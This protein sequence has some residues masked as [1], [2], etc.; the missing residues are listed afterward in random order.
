MIELIQFPFSSF[1]L[2][3]RR[4]LEY[5]GVL[6]KITNIPSTDRTLVWRL[7]RQRYYGVPIVRDGRTVVFETDEYSQVVAK[8]ID[9]KLQLNLFPTSFR[10]VDRIMWRYIED[11]VEDPCFKLNNVYWEKLV[12][13]G[14]RLA[15][16]RHKE[17][18]FGR[19]CLDQ[20]REQ[21]PQLLAQLTDALVPFEC[22]LAERPY[23][24]QTR[25]HFIDFELWGMLA[26]FLYTGDYKFPA[27]HTSLN[28]WYAR[29]SKL[30][31]ADLPSEKLH[32]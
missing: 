30:R 27:V 23:L 14:E 26:C 19:G 29:M 8:Y 22:M 2:V 10:G 18:K 9:G 7:T 15:F 31:K 21:R 25:P 11:K 4:I 17:R 28:E 13:K 20:W 1:C 16:V 6:F 24:L 3:Q 12:P 5:S 32:S